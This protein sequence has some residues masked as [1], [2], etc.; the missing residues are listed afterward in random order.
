MVP[1][2]C[3]GDGRSGGARRRLP[4]LWFGRA[5]ERERKMARE[6]ERDRDEGEA[7]RRL[8]RTSSSSAGRAGGGRVGHAGQGTQVPAC[9]RKKTRGVLPIAPWLFGK[10]LEKLKQGKNNWILA[11]CNP[12]EIQN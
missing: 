1:T 10:T 5:A 8:S 3:P 7:C 9:A 11:F 12:L 4:R 2:A 6:G